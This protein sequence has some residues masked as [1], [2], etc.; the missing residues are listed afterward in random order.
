MKIVKLK[1]GLGNQMFQYAFACLLHEHTNDEV[2]IDTSYFQSTIA[3]SIRQ[4]RLLQYK[5]TLQEAAK[6]EIE[7]LCLFRHTGNPM[8]TKY[9]YSIALEGVFNRNYYFEKNRAYVPVDDVKS[10]SYFDGYWQSWRNVDPIIEKLKNEFQPLNQLSNKTQTTLNK[11]STEQSVFIG[12]RRGDYSQRSGHFGSFG[13][14]Y[15]ETAMKYIDERVEYPVYYIFSND[16]EW[17]K[18][19]I[20]F[21]KRSI[22]FREKEDVVDDF[23]DLI[24]MSYCKHSIIIN[25][26]YH[27]WGARL[28]EYDGK[29]VIAPQK[30]FFDKKPI[31]IVPN[32]WIRI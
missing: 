27:W 30:W 14:D 9:R 1:G 17:V 15:F 24:L 32:R 2:K 20:D 31:D 12:I 3:D 8:G 18:N 29:I 6:E 21:G 28:H 5:L 11:I 13:Q 16:I 25:S 7:R 23:E 19:H 4:C 22:T 10:Y 26:T